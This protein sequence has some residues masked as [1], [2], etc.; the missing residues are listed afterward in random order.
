MP[1][2]TS[3]THEQV[4]NLIK[5]ELENSTLLNY[6]DHANILIIPEEY[7]GIIP[8]FKHYMIRIYPPMAGFLFKRPRIG[9]YYRNIYTV[10]IELWIKSPG[11]LVDRLLVGNI[12][13]NKGITEFFADVSEVLEHNTLSSNLDPF[14]GSNI[15]EASILSTGD[16][17]M[18]AM[19]FLWQGNQDNLR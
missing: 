9:Q 1:V 11:K 14:P 2:V 17:L 16:K 7:K 15:G 8:E 4:C 12:E 5:T 18:T 3:L 10:G 19:T 13:K 6:V